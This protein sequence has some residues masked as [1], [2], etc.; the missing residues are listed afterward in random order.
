MFLT[1]ISDASMSGSYLSSA[2]TT[3]RMS[4]VVVISRIL[5]TAGGELPFPF[6]ASPSHRLAVVKVRMTV[7]ALVSA[8][9]A[10]GVGLLATASSSDQ[11][12]PSQGSSYSARQCH[13]RHYRH[14]NRGRVR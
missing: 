10:A 1:L 12:G 3:S 6:V 11:A 9:A 13:H 5:P 14:P 8:M 7:P 2:S 4:C